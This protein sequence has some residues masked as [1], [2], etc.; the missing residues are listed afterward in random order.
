MKKNIALLLFALLCSAGTAEAQKTGAPATKSISQTKLANVSETSET[1]ES[2]SLESGYEMLVTPLKASIKLI[3]ADANGDCK[4]RTFKGNGRED[5]KKYGLAPLEYLVPKVSGT[6]GRRSQNDWNVNEAITKQVRSRVIF[7]FCR[8]TNADLIVMP[9]FRMAYVTD[10]VEV[11]DEAGNV[12]DIVAQPKEIKGRYVV[13]VE[14][15]GF[16]A[17]YT[18]FKDAQDADEWIK[19]VFR[20]GRINNNDGSVRIE[21]EVSKTVDGSSK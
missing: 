11:K 18:N 7:D 15:I 5:V 16:P 9:Q 4:H 8:E 12:I 17:R 3:D 21:D 10:E 20:M 1:V 13:E 2:F 19:K 14:M 6:P